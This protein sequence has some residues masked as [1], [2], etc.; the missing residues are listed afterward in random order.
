MLKE[1]CQVLNLT[2][3][4]RGASLVEL[5]IGTALGLLIVAGT[6]TLLVSHLGNSRRMLQEARINQDLRAAADLI[7]RDLRRAGYWTNAIHGT[8]SDRASQTAPKNPYRHVTGFVGTSAI[9]YTQSRDLVENDVVDSNDCAGIRLSGGAIQMKM[10]C[11]PTWQSLTDAG[12]VTVTGLAIVP[13]NT[14]IDAR[15]ACARSCCS[16]ADV[17]AA[18]PGCAVPNIALGASCPEVHVRRYQL[19]IT[20]A[21]FGDLTVRRSLQTTVRV[22]NDDVSGVCPS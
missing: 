16:H 15:D 22:R 5:M 20:A 8:I 10:N 12:S 2:R 21:A 13:T 19:S 9:E 14:R 4:E 6:A 7:S 17:G 11:T 1:H 18:L 3:H